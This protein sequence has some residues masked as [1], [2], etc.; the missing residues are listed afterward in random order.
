MQQPLHDR[1]P[2][3]SN[4]TIVQLSPPT[5][6]HAAHPS[7]S[8]SYQDGNT[9]AYQSISSSSPTTPAPWPLLPE[10]EHGIVSFSDLIHNVNA[11]SWF[12]IILLLLLLSGQ[13]IEQGYSGF[14]LSLMLLS[15]TIALVKTYASTPVHREIGINSVIQCYGHSM[16][17]AFLSC[18]VLEVL[19]LSFAAYV[20]FGDL[21]SSA[22]KLSHSIEKNE[23]FSAQ[24]NRPFSLRTMIFLTIMAFA[25]AAAPEE[26]MKALTAHPLA[27][28]RSFA[29]SK[30]IYVWA[31]LVTSIG[32][33]TAENFGYVFAI[34]SSEL[35]LRIGLA[36]ARLTAPFPIHVACACLTG[37]KV[38]RRKVLHQVIVQS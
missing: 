26:L 2:S 16:T 7:W 27:R 23:V 14:I 15:P 17:T 12:F 9:P 37:I 5:V 33:S 29:T 24:F 32:F 3:P 1:P 6:L 28:D 34:P 13:L 31:C 19:L 22:P 35:G 30:R 38:T 11:C 4:P 25:V 36:L 20:S 21:I 8:S 18:L 10:D